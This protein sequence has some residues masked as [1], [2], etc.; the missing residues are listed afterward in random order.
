ML[1]F[2]SFANGT[3]DNAKLLP[4]PLLSSFSSITIEVE[5]KEINLETTEKKGIFCLYNIYYSYI[6]WGTGILQTMG[7]EPATPSP[8]K[9]G[10]HVIKGGSHFTQTSSVGWK[11]SFIYHNI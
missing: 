11:E 5:G 1:N 10:V 3:F 2:S 7:V 9:L 4:S 6:P 8:K